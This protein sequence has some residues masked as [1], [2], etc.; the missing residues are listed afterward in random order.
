[1]SDVQGVAGAGARRAHEDECP[2]QHGHS[3]EVAQ[4][5]AARHRLRGQR[6][7]ITAPAMNP[8]GHSDGRHSGCLDE[9]TDVKR[10]SSLR[11]VSLQEMA[12]RGGNIAEEA[13]HL[14]GAT[15]AQAEGE[16]RVDHGAHCP[17][18]AGGAPSKTEHRRRDMAVV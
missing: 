12:S 18:Q 8:V 6:M 16:G 11:L 3:R 17:A 10:R 14:P 5:R 15:E 2:V 9:A 4:V 1:M 7:R 13:V